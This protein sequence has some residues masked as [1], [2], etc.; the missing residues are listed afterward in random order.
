MTAT[1]ALAAVSSRRVTR[2]FGA[3]RAVDGIDLEAAP[4]EFFA[5]LG[6]SGSGKTTCLRLIAGFDTPSAGAIDVF[7]TSRLASLVCAITPSD[8][9]FLTF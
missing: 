1:A 4:G 5:M 8:D 3:V 2:H 6:P 7:A 9:P